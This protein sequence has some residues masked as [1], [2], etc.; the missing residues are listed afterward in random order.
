MKE[1]ALHRELSLVTIEG[2]I[3]K[4][5][6]DKRISLISILKIADLQKLKIVKE[7][8]SEKFSSSIEKLKP[9]ME[10]LESN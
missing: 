4:L 9:I 3:I 6:Q 10:A 2:H 7:V 1:I 8:V 5:Y